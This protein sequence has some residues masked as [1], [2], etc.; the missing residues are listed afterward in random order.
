MPPCPSRSRLSVPA[1]LLCAALPAAAPAAV[2]A[3]YPFDTGLEDDSGNARHG[4]LVDTG[5]IGNSGVSTSAGNWR[6]GGGALDL[7]ADRDYVSVAARTFSSGSPWTIAFWVRKAPGDTGGAAQWDMVVGTAASTAFFIGLNNATGL[8]WRGADSTAARQADFPAPNDTSWHHVAV[9]ASAAAGG[10]ITAYVDGV[11]AGLATN[12]LTGFSYDAIGEAY[13]ASSDFDFNGQIDELW[14]FDETLTAAEI[15]NLALV[16]ARAAPAAVLVRHQRFDGDFTDASGNAPP[17]VPSG[18]AALTADPS[19]V[20]VGTGAL[21]NDGADASHV[22]WASPV[23]LAAGQ[24]WSVAFWARRGETGGNKGMVMGERNTTDD[25][26]WLNDSFTG[27][28]FRSSTNQS[29][30]FNAPKDQALHHYALVADGL[31]NLRLHV[32]GSPAAQTLAGNT[33]LRIDTIAQAYATNSLH[34]AFQGEL[35]DV[36]VY[37]GALTAAEVQALHALRNTGNPATVAS[38]RVFLI[39]GQSNADGRGELGALP[40]APRNLQLP[41]D[42]IDYVYRIPGGG[43]TLTTLRPGTS[44]TG[45][46]GPEVTLGP[47]LVSWLGADASNRVAILKYGNGGTSLA[48]HWTAGGDATTGGDGPDYV[49]FQQT[50]SE[51]LALLGAAYPGATVSLEGMVWMQGES[52]AGA[53]GA[54]AGHLAAFIADVRATLGAD[55][56]FVIA[57]LSSAQ[58]AV[59]GGLATLRA[60]QQAVADADPLSGWI[61]TDAYPVK[62]DD[63]HFTGAGQQSLGS[64]FARGLA[65]LRWVLAEFTPARR[66]GGAAEPGADADADGADNLNEFTA[67][68]G[69]VDAG[70]RLEGVLLP[71]PSANR[72]RHG[73]AAGARYFVEFRPSPADAW[74]VVLPEIPGTGAPVERVLP[75]APGTGGQYR[76]GAVRP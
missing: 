56:P 53:A 11:V 20:A 40:T 68:T 43:T 17:G 16:N 23:V 55:L 30:D 35:D 31:G 52:D 42:D 62:A 66:A 36:R 22:Q 75:A 37:T 47:G 54:Y 28:R 2:V 45:Q 4:T 18:N 38:V 10:T 8:R 12:K 61:D 51:G 63:L 5:T 46:F 73:T 19:R 48:T 69:P 72:L 64:D 3:H 29:L 6:F 71:D 67:R 25:F 76:V 21:V 44:E 65:Y 50:V 41:Q 57:R 70:S 33:S 32:D 49:V 26:I 74:A 27:L 15:A 60:A 34:Y 24:P 13:P 7:A 9:T 14:V 1:L 39:G 58:T 59:G